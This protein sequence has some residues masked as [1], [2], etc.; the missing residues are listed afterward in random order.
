MR[1][2]WI[3]V[4][5]QLA[6]FLSPAISQNSSSLSVTI[7]S[8]PIVGRRT[9]H[10]DSTTTVKQFLGIPFAQPPI[11]DLRFLPPD[12]PHSWTEVYNATS[13]PMACIQYSGPAGPARDLGKLL[14]NT[15]GPPGESEDC[16]YLNVYVPEG[17]VE[18]KAVLFWIYG[19]SNRAGA[20]SEPLYDGTSL[21]ANHDI[22]VV[23]I[24]YRLNVFGFPRAPQLPPAERNLGTLDQRLA[25]D[26]VQRNIHAFGGDPTKVTVMGESAG[27]M[28]VGN[29]INTYPDD[30][31]FRAGVLQSGSSVVKV[32][33]GTPNNDTTFWTN[34][35]EYLN[36]AGTSESGILDCARA[37]PADTL[38]TIIDNNAMAFGDPFMD[39]VTV[40]EY[41]ATVWATGDV[42]K[43]PILIG[44]TADDGSVFTLGIGDNNVTA[45]IEASFGVGSTLS[46]II[47][48]LYT[49][50]PTTT[51]G[52]TTG[53]QI[54]S[55]IATDATFRCT[56]GFVANLTSTL[57]DVPV[58]QYV[59]D[60]LVPSNTWEAYP[61][62]GVYHASEIA[63]IFGTYP[64]ENS[65]ETEARL[66]RSMQK[67]FADFVK[68]PVQGPG[69]NQWPDVAVLSVSEDDAV[70][71]VEN[72]RE[73]DEVCIAWDS[74]YT[75]ALSSTSGTTTNSATSS[76]STGTDSIGTNNA[77]P[78][79]TG[80]LG[81]VGVALLGLAALL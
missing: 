49:T 64:R 37:V 78:T 57:L 7:D 24:N 56:S 47:N 31:P 74:L 40:L 15:P 61:E 51:V 59:F 27:A 38:R 63:L 25:L 34:L 72:V 8:G 16:L 77:G 39:N 60:A 32:P 35:I 36:C 10:L 1:S 44:S 70:T 62:L 42:A 66:S 75:A 80:S 13:Q 21:A 2:L 33:P 65:T 73:L 50:D 20:A 26:W 6:L 3:A 9:Q 41:P 68:D 17:G 53:Q 29:F 23:A 22:I 67:Q 4:A 71:T 14:F 76:G 45:F 18:D 19:G 69:W 52:L 48:Q 81:T 30:P 79:L 5:L 12:P 58:W 55:Q 11:D 46:Q 54:I 28:A 43:V